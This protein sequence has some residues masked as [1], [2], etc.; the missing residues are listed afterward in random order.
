MKHSIKTYQF[1]FGALANPNRL[2]IINILRQGKKNVSEICQVTGFEQTMVS[3]NLKVLEYHGMVFR[4]K[5]G[6]FRYYA[7]NKKTIKP[8][9]EFIDT[10]MEEYCCRILEEKHERK[11]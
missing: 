10:H 2:Q 9:L 3:H 7:V 5:N 6:K 4:E 8:L 11:K 1:F